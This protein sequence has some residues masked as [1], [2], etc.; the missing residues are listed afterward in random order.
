MLA[1]RL[2]R[3]F[4]EETWQ[5]A[6]NE[7]PALPGSP[8]SPNHPLPRR[9]AYGAIG[10]LLGLTGGLGTAL[11]SVNTIYLQGP[12]GLDPSEIAWLPTAYVMT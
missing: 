6:P 9:Y 8:A 1:D 2:R 5:F 7:R 12:L 11:I 4:A 3:F 10:V